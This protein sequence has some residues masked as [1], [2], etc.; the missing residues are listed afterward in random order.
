MTS[1]VIESEVVLFLLIDRGSVLTLQ[2]RAQHAEHITQARTRSLTDSGQE[3]TN[4]VRRTSVSGKAP[5]FT[6]CTKYLLPGND[7]TQGRAV[8]IEKPVSEEEYKAA[9][10]FM[11][12]VSV[13]YRHSIRIPGAIMEV[14]HMIPVGST[15]GGN[16]IKVD[17]EGGRQD[18]VPHYL[19]LLDKY[20]ITVARN[21]TAE[22]I[23][24]GKNLGG[25]L[26]SGPEYNHA[27]K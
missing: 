23:K 5:V 9:I 25:K 26:M 4:R 20:G 15:R 3:I 16:F 18:Q 17:I 10:P 21:L 14:D 24:E 7:M 6:H 13:K 2:A 1:N 19:E 12:T 22:G 27:A 11:G 8:E